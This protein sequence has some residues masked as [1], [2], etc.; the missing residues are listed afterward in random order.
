MKDAIQVADRI[1]HEIRL[2]AQG[3]ILVILH[4]DFDRLGEN[5]LQ[6]STAMILDKEVSYLIKPIVLPLTG[7]NKETSNKV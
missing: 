3:G 2:L 7:V 1:E 6:S 5:L 4:E